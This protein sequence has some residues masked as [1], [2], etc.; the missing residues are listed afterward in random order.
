MGFFA[1]RGLETEAHL[2]DPHQVTI[3]QAHPCGGDGRIVHPC[4]GHRA[5][6]ANEDRSFGIAGDAGM[7]RIDGGGIQPDLRLPAVRTQ[8]DI[9]ILK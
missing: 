8:S 1:L 6:V 9:V 3:L 7:Q 2:S 5:Q 4:T